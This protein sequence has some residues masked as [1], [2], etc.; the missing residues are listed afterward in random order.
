[1]HWLWS[2]NAALI[3]SA[4]AAFS[5]YFC[6][7][8]FRKPFS[9]G[10]YEDQELWG[11]GLKSL[12]VTSQ[13]LGY[14]L[15][16][17]IGI[18]V[19]SEMP[20]KYR[21]L[22]IVGLIGFAE[23]ALIGFAILPMPFKVV[24]LFLNGLPLGMVFG[25]VLAYLEGRKNTEA[26][27]AVLCASFIMSSGF[28]KTMGRSLIEN[29]GVS[30]FAMPMV[31]GAIF[32]VPLLI[33]VWLLQFT[34]KPDEQDV[35]LRSVRS[36]MN[37]AQRWEFMRAYWP[38]LI[39]LL[40]I[41]VVL[42]TV[43]TLRDDFGV[44]LWAELKEGGEPEVYAISET[45]VAVV[46]T[47]FSGAIIWVRGNLRAI[48]LCLLS[49][50]A[51]FGLTLFS[52]I[53]QPRGSISPM[54]FMVLCG[55]GLYIPYVAFH[56]TIFERL[57]ALSRRPG[58][59]GFLMYLADAIG[60]LGYSAALILAP[61]L[62]ESG[63]VLSAFRGVLMASAVCSGLMILCLIVYFYMRF[64]SKSSEPGKQAASLQV[65]AQIGTR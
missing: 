13:L 47:A 52:A 30:E 44:E 35:E 40:L 36:E 57:I 42:T 26:L 60:Y 3:L 18:K 50:A 41:Y 10:T 48:Q 33:S 7:Y 25:L 32:T 61:A 1:M 34:P 2:R 62:T 24:C 27:A 45:A 8:A 38:G 58:N 53:A 17:F 39:L 28:V 63:G 5:T 65:D 31:V 54:T 22:G 16:K 6:M 64:G 21:A 49:M 4:V 59:L 56:T 14:V 20:A 55:I 19:I 12:L 9:A 37:G 43:R 51:A 15:S 29:Y 46:V 23:L 11:F